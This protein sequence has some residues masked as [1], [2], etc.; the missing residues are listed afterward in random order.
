MPSKPMS[1]RAG[2]RE[3]SL[4]HRI[5]SLHRPSVSSVALTAV[6]QHPLIALHR[7]A[8]NRSVHR[9]LQRTTL[10]KDYSRGND[11]QWECCYETAAINISLKVDDSACKDKDKDKGKKVPASISYKA[12]LGGKTLEADGTTPTQGSTEGPQHYLEEKGVKNAT[13]ENLKGAGKKT[14]PDPGKSLSQTLNLVN[15]PTCG[16]P[17]Q[18]GCV[19]VKGMGTEQQEIKWSATGTKAESLEANQLV[20]PPNDTMNRLKAAVPLRGKDGHPK[21]KN[22]QPRHKDCWCDPQTGY[23]LNYSDKDKCPSN[24]LAA[25]GAKAPAPYKSLNKTKKRSTKDLPT[26]CELEKDPGKIC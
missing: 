22:A 21:F 3:S 8:G 5:D 6:R 15:L 1:A 11:D 16:G 14:G 23:H 19:M 4:A 20:Q 13:Q 10:T 25:G 7:A 18:N 2:R 17:T 26:V 24:Y 9:L 12:V